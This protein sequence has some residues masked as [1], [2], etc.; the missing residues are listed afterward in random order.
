[1][2]IL[3][4]CVL[5]TGCA[6][7][8][9]QHPTKSQQQLANDTADCEARAELATRKIRQANTIDGGMVQAKAITKECLQDKGW[10]L[11]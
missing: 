11:E 3:I 4:L 7:T 2:R 1:M 5:L 10:R 6:S 8:Q 9:W